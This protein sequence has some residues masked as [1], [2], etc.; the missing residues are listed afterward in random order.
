VK[1]AEQEGTPI[2]MV[3]NWLAQLDERATRTAP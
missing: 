3:V 2:N 1:E